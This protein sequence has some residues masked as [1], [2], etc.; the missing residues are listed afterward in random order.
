MTNII[1]NTIQVYFE[2]QVSWNKRIVEQTE[3]SSVCPP[4]LAADMYCL[5]AKQGVFILKLL[6]SDMC[7]YVT[8]I[9]KPTFLNTEKTP[10]CNT[11][12][13]KKKTKTKT[14]KKHLL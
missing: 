11:A 8:S 5:M 4:W 10:N 9:L 14:K 1:N 7:E 3:A 13:L 12:Y 2:E 6:R